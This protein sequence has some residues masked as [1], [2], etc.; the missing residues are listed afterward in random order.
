MLPPMFGHMVTDLVLT[1]LQEGKVER[2]M[3]T[4]LEPIEAG[5]GSLVM[6]FSLL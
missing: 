2:D 4:T 3:K 5:S 6:L 1:S